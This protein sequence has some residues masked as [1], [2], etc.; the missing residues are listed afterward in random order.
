MKST[1]K[2]ISAI[3]A[4]FA[5]LGLLGM[6]GC[7]FAIPFLGG[8]VVA[9]YFVTSVLSALVFG[10]AGVTLFEMQT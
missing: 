9:G 3:F 8:K 10:F 2:Y 4:L 6:F 5:V 1:I 7:I